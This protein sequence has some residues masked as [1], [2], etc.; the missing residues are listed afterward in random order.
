[1][2]FAVGSVVRLKSGGPNMT[3]AEVIGKSEDP[4]INGLKARGFEEGDVVVEYFNESSEL[5]KHTFRA[6]SLE[7]T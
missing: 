1:M 5:I 7:F 4:K 6:T 2:E 3:V